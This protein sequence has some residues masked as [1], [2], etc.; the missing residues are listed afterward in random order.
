MTF[1]LRKIIVTSLTFVVTILILMPFYIMV[2]MG[3]YSTYDLFKGLVILPGNHLLANFYTVITGYFPRS[4]LNSLMVTLIAMVGALLTSSLAGYAFAKYEFSGKKS[5]FNICLSTMMIPGQLGLIAFS[6]QINKMGLSNT[7]F[8]LIVP[9][10]ASMFGVFWFTQFIRSSVPKEILE[11]ARVDGCHELKMFWIMVLPLIKSAI[12]S[13]GL[14]FFLWNWN[15]Y[16][17][18]LVIVSKPELYTVPLAI[19][20]LQDA[21]QIDYGAQIFGL[22]IGCLPI[23]ILFVIFSKHFISGLTAGAVKG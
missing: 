6:W 20:A 12:I 2:V 4:F 18:P 7:H 17:V 11:S 8:A 22:T 14:M 23:I 21:Y 3:S 10:M 5:I 1:R 9:P 16:L 19:K 13:L 15:S